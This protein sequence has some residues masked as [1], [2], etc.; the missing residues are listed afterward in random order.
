MVISQYLLDYLK[1]YQ[2]AY[3]YQHQPL[4]NS[5]EIDDLALSVGKFYEKIRKVIDWKDENALRR[6]AITRAFK[7]KLIGQFYGLNQKYTRETNRQLASEFVFELMR[8]GYFD[9]KLIN[10]FKVQQV[11]EIL[12]KYAQILI[13][14]NL[15]KQTV[16][17]RKDLKQ[18]IKFQTWILQIAS[19]EIEDCLAPAFKEEALAKMMIDVLQ[20]RIKVLPRE[21]LSALEEKKIILMSVW[22]ALFGADDYLVAYKLIVFEH[23]NLL[24]AEN[25]IPD[26]L[27]EE[28]F[29][30]QNKINQD[31]NSKTNR[32]F[33]RLANKYDAAF[34]LIGDI[35][36]KIAPTKL[37]EAKSVWQ[38]EEKIEKLYN[39][40]YQDRYKSLKRRLLR[41]SFWTTLSI[42]VGNAFSVVAIEGPVAYLLGLDFGWFSIIM[43]ILIPTFAMFL[44]VM[45]IRPPDKK[46]QPIVWQEILKIGQKSEKE[47][48]YEIRIRSRGD[49]KLVHGIFYF[50]VF[51]AGAFGL[52]FFY[53]IFD[54]V[55]MPWTSIYLNIVYITMV[56]SAS[57]GIR[58][59]ASEITI[60]EKSS[61]FDFILDIFSIPLA[62]IGRWFSRKWKE[63]NIFSIFFSVLIDTP[64]SFF[65]SF[66]EDWREFL[67][68]KKAEF[69]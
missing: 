24:R 59:Q 10:T 61:L 34:R 23:Q 11:E 58:H 30:A 36:D 51:V 44:L 20:K 5:F 33:L 16:T 54:L 26:K 68:E 41:T 55:G 6:G 7:R 69:N 37:E 50:F 62:R 13:A 32:N 21:K 25:F 1:A 9:N 57:L 47:D 67:R 18:K 17:K 66:I 40:I 48:V 3:D 28:F 15:Q 2:E 63:Y 65:I 56:V 27:L 49:K 60:Y 64:L 14:L 29:Q 19:C 38:D 53:F 43:D 4:I 22:R 12:F 39:Q 35:T 31:L 52:W 8:S 45:M 42:L 46:N